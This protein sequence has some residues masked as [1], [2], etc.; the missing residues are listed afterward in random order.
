MSCQKQFCLLIN[1]LKLGNISRGY[2]LFLKKFSEWVMQSEYICIIYENDWMDVKRFCL[3]YNLGCHGNVL[4]M[5]WEHST[6]NISPPPQKKKHAS[7][8]QKVMMKK[9]RYDLPY[10]LPSDF[11]LCDTIKYRYR[12]N[13]RIASPRLKKMNINTWL[14]F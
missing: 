12:Y 13:L 2:T 1:P 9:T 4:C 5:T 7:L 6:N 3:A 11:L 8:L 10:G 14:S